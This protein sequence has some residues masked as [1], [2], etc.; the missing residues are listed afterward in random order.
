MNVVARM[1][2]SVGI[3]FGFAVM[4]TV[5]GCTK[6][7]PELLRDT[8][9]PEDLLY[10]VVG[11][12]I[13]MQGQPLRVRGVNALQTFGLGAS[14]DMVDWEIGIV[15]EFIGNL[16]E[17]PID[18]GPVLASDGNWYHP[19]QT[20]VDQHRAAGRI[21][22]L[23][24][25]GWVNEQGEQ[26]LFTGLNPRD[27]SFYGAYSSKMRLLA[28]HFKDQP[29]VWI[30]VWNEPY[31]W[32]NANG[33]SDDKWLADMEA[34]VDNLRSVVGF[35]N[36]VV[37]PG[38]EQGQSERVLLARAAELA[39]G[40]YN[41]VYDLHA[42]EKWMIGVSEDEVRVRLAELRDSGIPVVFGEMGVEN[43]SGLMDAGPFLRAA[44]AVDATVLAWL[45]NTNSS[46]VNALRTDEGVPNDADNGGWGSAFRA[47][48]AREM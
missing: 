47:F 22:I 44:D 21:T 9:V 34:L 1:M 31:S 11:A 45:W 41:L 18:G 29:D 17:Q 39:L 8:N 5:S 7:E 20:I 23:C 6:G 14:E 13:L 32:Q 15:R 24:P 43:A 40:R 28:A 10:E 42:Y 19:L 38:A 37:V 27:Q 16:R 26:Q 33:Y 35:T 2:K 36:V 46:D 30:E 4:L 48:L 25:F 3:V 12:D